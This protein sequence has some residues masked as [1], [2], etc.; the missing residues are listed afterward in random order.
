MFHP[1]TVD[2][3][4]YTNTCKKYMATNQFNS[5]EFEG[6]WYSVYS[7]KNSES[8]L[9]WNTATFYCK[10]NVY[11][12]KPCRWACRP[13]SFMVSPCTRTCSTIMLYIS[14][15]TDDLWPHPLHFFLLL[16]LFVSHY[17]DSFSK[18]HNHLCSCSYHPEILTCVSSVLLL[19]VHTWMTVCSLCSFCDSLGSYIVCLYENM[20]KPVQNVAIFV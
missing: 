16:F 10:C 8:P 17:Q 11:S 6:V 3:Q 18:T 20:V 5:Y 4:F 9:I 15:A 1:Y 19:N 13:S 7:T 2:S 14:T 12:V